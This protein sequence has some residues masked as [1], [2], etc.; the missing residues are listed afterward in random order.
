M[1]VRHAAAE[2]IDQLPRGHPGW[3]E[4]D[5]GI[6]H[7]SRYREGPQ[8]IA[9]VAAL[10]GE[11]VRAFLDDVAHPEERLDVVAQGRPPEQSDL[12]RERRPLPRESALAF[13]ALEH[14]RFFAADIGARA[15]AQVDA[16][17]VGYPGGRDRGDLT[18]EDRAALR[19]I[20]A[21]IE[22]DFGDLDH[23]RSDQ[24][25]LKHAVGIGFEEG[26]VVEGAGFPPIG[27]DR[28][29]P[30]RRLLPH[31]APF[32]P[33][34]KPRP[35]EPAK[36]GMLEHL[37]Q[38]FGLALASQARFEET[39]AA[40]RAISVK[41]DNLRDHRVRLP[42]RDS[43]GDTLQGGV[44]MQRMA[45]RHDR[46]A[47]AAAHAGRANDAD[48]VAE[49]AAQIFEELYGTGELA[50]QTVADPHGQRRRW[51]LA[52][53]DDVEMGVERGDLVDLDE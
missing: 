3:G 8:P 44:L 22:I 51:G 46:G 34:R 9:P 23:P 4:L 21:E 12:G 50:T 25:A 11:P 31:Q 45:D 36:A 13:D 29:E 26:T 27:I 19:I 24:Y 37:D 53:H 2:F 20:I 35:A 6:M 43:R 32:A 18:L 28:D 15:A 42:R 5:P 10:A 39:I 7:P 1:A 17:M 49:P 16:R 48:M 38:L 14:R 52:V 33:R 47:M 41:A 30:G 40:G